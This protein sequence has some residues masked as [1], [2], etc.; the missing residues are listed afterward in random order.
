MGFSFKKIGRSLGRLAPVFAGALPFGIANKLGAFGKE[1]SK[2]SSAPLIDENAF[3]VLDRQKKLKDISGQTEL[4]RGR[5]TASLKNQNQ[6]IGQLQQQ[7][8]GQGP[9]L[10]QVQLKAAA[11]R[12]LAQQMAGAA[13]SRGGN[14][15]AVQRQLMQN[16]AA[17]QRTLGQQA[18]E[19]GIQEQ[20]SAQQQLGG[21]V[22]NEQNM[23][24]SLASKYMQSG[25]DVDSAQQAAQIELQKLKVGRS[26]AMEEMDQKRHAAN[27]AREVDWTDKLMG[28]AGGVISLLSDKK[29][30]KNIESGT[31]DMSDFYSQISS[32]KKLSDEKEKKNARSASHE[33][34]PR[35]RL[36]SL[37]EIMNDTSDSGGEKPLDE[38]LRNKISN[39]FSDEK[40]KKDISSSDDSMKGF[41]GALKAHKYEYKNPDEPGAA[42]G[43]HYS[44]MAQELEKAGPVGKSMVTEVNGKKMVDYG[45]GFGAILAAQAAMHERMEKLEKK[46]G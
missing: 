42:P 22:Q 16:Q 8:L 30:K 31:E 15:A 40:M 41:L 25:L 19:T 45:R 28:G 26:T 37:S 12:S 9:S 7:A 20:R 6:L 46:R 38:T 5:S 43:T 13:A 18:A 21:L 14:P 11:D 39:I 32:M 10:A 23:A 2:G 34:P 1:G 3:N 35:M 33:L 27:R 36:K 4:A 24:D 17:G 44:V 29:T